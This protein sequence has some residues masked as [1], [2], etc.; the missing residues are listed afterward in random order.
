MTKTLQNR[1]TIFS[2]VAPGILVFFGAVFF[3]IILSVYYGMTDST[4]INDMKFIGLRNYIELITRDDVFWTALLHSFLIGVGYIVLQ[5]PVCVVLAVMLDKLSGKMEKFFRAVYFVPSVVSVVIVTKMWVYMYNSDF[6]IFNKL[7][8]MIGLGQYKQQ[9]LGDTNISFLCILIMTTWIGFGYGFL[10]YYAGIKGIPEELYEAARIDGASELKL[11]T[12]I[13]LP[14]LSP[15]IKVN[16]T[17]AMINALKQMEIIYLAT[18]GGPANSTQVLANYLY[19]KA[20]ASFQYGYANAISVVFAIICLLTTL[21]FN[22][23]INKD[24][25]VY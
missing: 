5:H 9:W 18:N 7:L 22:K 19:S 15:I 25:G 1:W 8:E 11:Y 23:L 24:I 13:M 3:P 20:F 16:V 17:L 14:L 10:M 6:G 12:R 21:L 2:L 4:G